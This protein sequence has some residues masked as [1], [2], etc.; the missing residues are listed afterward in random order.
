MPLEGCQYFGWEPVCQLCRLVE[1]VSIAHQ[2][3]ET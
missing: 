3:E 2:N 1:G